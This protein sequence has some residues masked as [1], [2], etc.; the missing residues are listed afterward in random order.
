MCVCEVECNLA[1]I[2]MHAGEGFINVRPSLFFG[3]ITLEKREIMMAI[4]EA[5]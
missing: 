3:I 1:T 4:S 2:Y 5:S